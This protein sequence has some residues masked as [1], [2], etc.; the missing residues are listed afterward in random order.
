LAVFA[1]ISYKYLLFYVDNLSQNSVI[2]PRTAEFLLFCAVFVEKCARF[3]VVAPIAFLF[4][5]C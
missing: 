1:L 5:V 2:L 4:I 3:L